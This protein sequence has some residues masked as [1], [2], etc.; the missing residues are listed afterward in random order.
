MMKIENL[1]KKKWRNEPKQTCVFFPFSG[2]VLKDVNTPR[3]THLVTDSCRGKNFKYASTFMIPVMSGDWIK[4][5][6]SHRYS[7]LGNF[8]N[9]YMLIGRI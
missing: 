2:S 4:A 1:E 8:R 6:W 3:V 7:V 5:S 9:E